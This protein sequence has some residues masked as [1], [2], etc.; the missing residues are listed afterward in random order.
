MTLYLGAISGT[1][2]D[3]MDLALVEIGE[4]ISI[5]SW[6]T[7]PFD[8][9]LATGLK[10]LGQGLNDNLES[11]GHLDAEL[12]IALGEAAVTFLHQSGVAAHE[13]A[14]LGWHGQ[15]VRHRPDA[16]PPFTLQIGDPNR[17]AEIT[18][19]TTVADFRRRD[20]AAAGQGAPLVP[21]FHRVLFRH[22]AQNRTILN[23]GGIANITNL[24]SRSGVHTDPLTGFDTGPGNALLDSWISEQKNQ[25]YD[26]DGSWAGTGE[27]QDT[28]L[29][30]WLSDPYFAS[31][32][33]KS[34]GREYFNLPWL[35]QGIQLSH[36]DPA[37]VQASLVELSARS[38]ADAIA[39]W[40]LPDGAVIVCGGGRLN[41]ALMNAIGAALPGYTVEPSESYGHNGDAIEAATFA[42]LAH[43]RLQGLPGNVPE[44]TGAGGDRILGGVYQGAS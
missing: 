9:T 10:D 3:G 33:P 1:S 43:R 24:P 31:Q 21:A 7:L 14:A 35:Q 44:V 22:E 39:A 32:P 2:V 15:T 17:I 25:A 4:G 41:S 6:D 18:G 19:L 12:G 16:L 20:M 13:V 5:I 30:H 28:L 27:V 34:T 38:I 37:D 36:Y 26:K 23:I 11:L 40:G 8:A 42:W 29:N